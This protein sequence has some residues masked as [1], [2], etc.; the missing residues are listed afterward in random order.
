MLTAIHKAYGRLKNIAIPPMTKEDRRAQFE[1]KVEDA[2]S[3]V[4]A[5]IHE[6]DNLT[7][8]YT[9]L[10]GVENFCDMWGRRNPLVITRANEMKRDITARFDVI[11]N[12][13]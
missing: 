13:L 10:D 1:D 4:F 2:A 3:Y 12:N 9:A 6:C 5:Q 8:L 7:Q 11:S